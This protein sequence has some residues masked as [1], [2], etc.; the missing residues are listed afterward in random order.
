MTEDYCYDCETDC[1]LNADCM[2]R[3]GNSTCE[4]YPGFE[5]DPVSGNCTDINECDTGLINDICNHNFKKESNGVCVAFQTGV[6]DLSCP[7]GWVILVI[8]ANYGR[9]DVAD[10]RDHCCTDQQW[11]NGRCEALF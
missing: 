4:C 9:P 6:I 7:V 8:S 5:L 2:V 11:R 10:N 3:N 1:G